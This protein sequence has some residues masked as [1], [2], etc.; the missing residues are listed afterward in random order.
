M[1][2]STQIPVLI[3][4]FLT[5]FFQ[6]LKQTQAQ[7]SPKD[8]IISG[9]MI[10]TSFGFHL[11]AGDLAQ[12]YGES[13]TGGFGIIYKTKKNYTFGVEYNFLFGSKVKIHDDLF[14]NIMTQEGFV[15]DGD[16]LY[17]EIYTQQRGFHA[18]AKFGKI[19]PIFGPNDNCGPFINF[20]IGML[21]H[22][23]RIV[24]MENTA[25]QVG[26]DLR[27]G[28]D[29]LSSGISLH[30]QIGYFN[31]GNKKAF[32]FATSFEAIQAFTL[33]RRPYQYDL[34]GPEDNKIRVD[35]LFGMKLTWMVPIYRQASD[36]FYFN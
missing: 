1:K 20:G 2:K 8:S 6:N 36:G 18:N 7:S 19:F 14:K 23:I 13:A 16:G 22:R 15:I 27:K 17:A 33:P 5:I 21:Q 30:Q 10:E 3:L 11:P 32:S 29:R 28:Y 25:P 24:N 12:R 35:L 34:M 4:I 31:I 9:F 26:P